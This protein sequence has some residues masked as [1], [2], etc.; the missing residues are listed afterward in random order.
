MQE[1][2]DKLLNI[3]AEMQKE[4]GEQKVDPPPL[5]SEKSANIDENA[6]TAV[7]P[8]SLGMKIQGAPLPG[9]GKHP[10]LSFDDNTLKTT[11][12]SEMIAMYGPTEGSTPGKSC[13]DDFGNG[14]VNRWR[15]T[16]ELYCSPN[17]TNLGTVGGLKSSIDCYLVKQTRHGGNG[18]QICVMENI[19]INMD[20]F[21]DDKLMYDTVREYEGTK[22]QKQPYVRFPR[23]FVRSA[24][25]TNEDKWKS[26][27]MP[28]WNSGESFIEI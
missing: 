9:A 16:K 12:I 21:N 19:G 5:I 13:D 28:G 7:K 3:L 22:H 25:E 27:F 24:C 20:I 8:P 17:G 4:N 18:D 23:G 6:E 11:K 15:K 2:R 14:L 1:E 10:I 26:S